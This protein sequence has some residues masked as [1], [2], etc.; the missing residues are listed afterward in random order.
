M[1]RGRN[2]PTGTLVGHLLVF[3]LIM[4][5]ETSQ[6]KDTS[7]R[8]STWNFNEKFS[9]NYN[10]KTKSLRKLNHRDDKYSIFELLYQI[11]IIYTLL[12]ILNFTKKIFTCVFFPF[13]KERSFNWTDVKNRSLYLISLGKFVPAGNSLETLVFHV[14]T[15]KPYST[16]YKVNISNAY[17]PRSFGDS[18]VCL[19]PDGLLSSGTLWRRGCARRSPAH[20]AGGFLRQ[21]SETA[22]SSWRPTPP[23]CNGRTPPPLPPHHIVRSA[24]SSSRVPSIPFLSHRRPLL[25]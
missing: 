12:Y 23:Q 20:G 25:T 22:P 5:T 9:K 8:K 2:D 15:V 3:A 7:S 21:V 4:S 11:I 24:A 6:R 16:S 1:F 14:P 13:I 18:R 19:G 10:G 17:F